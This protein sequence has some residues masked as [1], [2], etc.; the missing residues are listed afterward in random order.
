MNK[1]TYVYLKNII[2]YCCIIVIIVIIIIDI[3]G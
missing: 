2:N 1:K 3:G